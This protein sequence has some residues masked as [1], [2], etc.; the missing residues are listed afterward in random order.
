MTERRLSG[1]SFRL[2]R[3]FLNIGTI[4]DGFQKSGKQDL[5]FLLSTCQKDSQQDCYLR[6]TVV[7]QNYH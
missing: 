5:E 3:A 6:L 4:N 2:L 7:H 1:C